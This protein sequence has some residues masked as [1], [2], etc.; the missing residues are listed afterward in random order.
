MRKRKNKYSEISIANKVVEY[1]SGIRIDYI[2]ITRLTKKRKRKGIHFRRSK[3]I[4]EFSS[5][6]I[7]LFALEE[8]RNVLGIRFPLVI[9]FKIPFVSKL[10]IIL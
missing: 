10:E 2:Q 1:F 9:D 8:K 3:L 4:F 5:F 7:R 6:E